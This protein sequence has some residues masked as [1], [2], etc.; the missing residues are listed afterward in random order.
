MAIANCCRTHQQM[1]L[2]NVNEA[3]RQL[4]RVFPRSAGCPR[5]RHRVLRC[6]ALLARRCRERSWT[7]GASG[8]ALRARY[9]ATGLRV[10]DRRQPLRAAARLQPLRARACR[11]GTRLKTSRSSLS[12]RSTC[13]FVHS[14][15]LTPSIR[16]R[17]QRCPGRCATGRPATG[18]PRRHWARMGWCGGS[19][20]WAH[21]HIRLKGSSS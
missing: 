12:R 7:A 4:V 9:R 13:S 20:P 14:L 5:S 2:L 11:R 8:S 16:W 17:T 18:S 10:E 6:R 19:A 3:R 15:R 1:L 21:L